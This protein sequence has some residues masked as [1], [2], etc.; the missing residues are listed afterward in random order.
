MPSFKTIY[1]VITI[2]NLLVICWKYKEIADRMTKDDK[3]G[4]ITEPGYMGFLL[5]CALIPIINL[6]ILLCCF[7][8]LT[9]K[10][11]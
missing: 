10:S 1:L 2:F 7:E 6:F 9:F 5:V 8:A 3:D 4:M 11:K